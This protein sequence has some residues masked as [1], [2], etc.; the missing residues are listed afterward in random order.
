MGRVKKNRGRRDGETPDLQWTPLQH[1]CGDVVEWGWDT[2][3]MPPPVFMELCLSVLGSPCM[4][5]GAETG[6]QVPLDQE[7]LSLRTPKGRLYLRQA[8]EA[9]RELGVDLTR[10]ARELK[11]KAEQGTLLADL[12]S[13][14]VRIMEAKGYDPVDAWLDMRMAD[15]FLNRGRVT[16]TEGMIAKLPEPKA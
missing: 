14:W 2:K 15:I 4:W 1:S 12:P 7:M 11:D 9:V 16:L 10:Q 8:K 3:A 6:I 5:H 13:K